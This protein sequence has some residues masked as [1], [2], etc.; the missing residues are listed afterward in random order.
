MKL[1]E[2]LFGTKTP[3]EKQSEYYRKWYQKKRKDLDWRSERTKKVREYQR[4]PHGKLVAKRWRMEN[5]DKIREMC[6]SYR[7]ANPE[8]IRD[9]QRIKYWL[10][11]EKYRLKAKAWRAKNPEK[12]RAI[13]RRW[14]KRNVEYQNMMYQ[15]DPAY[16]QMKLDNSRKWQK[17]NPEKIK[18]YQRKWRLKNPEKVR[19]YLKKS[20]EK[21][22]LLDRVVP[23]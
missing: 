17:E 11:P 13:V 22:R 18:E 4:S 3:Q 10:N 16:R 23:I 12:A 15:V 14:S 2:R 7:Q 1:L 21:R 9:Q 6:R 8:K 20:A 19:G 5:K